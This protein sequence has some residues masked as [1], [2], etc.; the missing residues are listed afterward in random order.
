[1]TRMVEAT[2]VFERNGLSHEPR[3][4]RQ[5]DDGIY[6]CAVCI[7][8]FA[9]RCAPAMSRLE[10]ILQN[11]RVRSSPT[12]RCALQTDRR[13]RD[14][15][16]RRDMIWCREA[17]ASTS[18][19]VPLLAVDMPLALRSSGGQAGNCSEAPCVAEECSRASRPTASRAAPSRKPRSGMQ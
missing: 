13:S 10:H 19:G 11:R 1:M 18:R 16:P 3:A 17:S 5:L 9:R 8:G 6:T 7:P 4:P 2:T 14:R 15:L 12:S